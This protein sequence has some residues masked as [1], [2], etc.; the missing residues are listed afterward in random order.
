MVYIFLEYRRIVVDLMQLVLLFQA[1]EVFV[2]GL[3]ILIFPSGLIYTFYCR[4]LRE[5]LAA[6]SLCGGA[7]GHREQW[8]YVSRISPPILFLIV[9]F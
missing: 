5:W 9:L 1:F 6:Y 8:N 4:F 3:E 7:T 2:Y